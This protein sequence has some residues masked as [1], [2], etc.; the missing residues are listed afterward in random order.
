[1]CTHVQSGDKQ[2]SCWGPRACLHRGEER[3][4]IGLTAHGSRSVGHRRGR[5]GAL[6]ILLPW[7]CP[8]TLDLRETTGDC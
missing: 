4:L 1:M 6:C 8:S 5:R 3:V 2:G 7:P